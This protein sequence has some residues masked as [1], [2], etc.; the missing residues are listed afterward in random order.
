MKIGIA[1]AR[2]FKGNVSAN[3]EAHRKLIDSALTYKADAVFFPELSLTGY[4]PA[5]ANELASHQDDN[6][7]DIF[8][9]ISDQYKIIIGVGLPT[10]S[11]TIPRISMIIFTPQQARQTYSKQQLHSDEFPYFGSGEGQVIIESGKSKIAPA[12]CYESL[13][14]SHAANSFGLGANIYVASVAKSANGVE[15][16]FQHFPVIAKRYSMPVFMANSLGFCDNFLSVGR[17]S[18][19]SK[20]GRLIAQLDE[21]SEGVLVYDT[22]TEELLS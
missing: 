8:Q 15:K 9:Q 5:L 3:V 6:E 21:Q 10:R 14:P 17:S 20:D 18:V 13:Q 11:A 12:I 2:P 22:E 7:L 16:A 1:Q 19:W 4:E